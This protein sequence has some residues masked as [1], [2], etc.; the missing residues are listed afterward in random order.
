[1]SLLADGRAAPPAD[2]G[3]VLPLPGTVLAVLNGIPGMV[4]YWDR[5]LRNRLA[6]D[7]YVEYFGLTPGEILGRHMRD[8]LG[9]ALV[10]ANLPHLT[11]VLAG[12]RVTFD[13]TLT[14][15]HD[16]SRSVQVSYLPDLRDGR[17]DGFFVLV[18][19]ISER[20]RAERETEAALASWRALARSMPRGFVL[21]FDSDL[22]F[23]IADGVALATFGFTRERLEGCLL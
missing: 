2:P 6:N 12:E 20:V 23:Q 22:R 5:D 14:T 16:E 7:A 4:G 21:V 17:V 1:M 9:D 13:R 10:D 19:D 18:T 11:R 15:V 3:D 8:V